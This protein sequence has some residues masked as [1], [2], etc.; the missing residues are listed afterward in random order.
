MFIISIILISSYSLYSNHEI[1]IIVIIM[2]LNI[3]VIMILSFFF[4][5]LLI[6]YL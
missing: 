4:A 1:E 6:Q 2:V 5:E 3:E